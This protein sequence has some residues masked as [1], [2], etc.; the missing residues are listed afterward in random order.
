MT[1]RIIHFPAA[2]HG[3]RK[4]LKTGLTVTRATRSNDRVGRGGKRKPVKDPKSG[5][6]VHQRAYIFWIWEVFRAVRSFRP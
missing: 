5:G 1:P 3:Q 2:F 4:V 6:A